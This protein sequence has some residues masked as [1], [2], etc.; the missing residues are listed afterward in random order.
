MSVGSFNYTVSVP[1][2]DGASTHDFTVY[3]N[4]NGNLCPARLLRIRSNT[5]DGMIPKTDE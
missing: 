2:H 1:R 5:M 3:D 4:R